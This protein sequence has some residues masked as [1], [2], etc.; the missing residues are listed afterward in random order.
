MQYEVRFNYGD[1]KQHSIVDRVFDELSSVREYIVERYNA[2]RKGDEDRLSADIV[3]EVIMENYTVN[4]LDGPITTRVPLHWLV[5]LP[6]P[7]SSMQ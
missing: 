1:R 4:E 3:A 7:P 5:D 2:V 6:F